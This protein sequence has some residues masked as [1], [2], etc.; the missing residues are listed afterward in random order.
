MDI[1]QFIPFIIFGALAA[2]VVVGL[3][4]I[5]VVMRQ[6][7]RIKAIEQFLSHQSAALGKIHAVLKA[8]RTSNAFAENAEIV[9][10]D[11]LQYATPIVRAAEIP[12][13]QSAEH[14]LWRA[15]GGMLDEYNRNPFVLEQ[16]RRLIKLDSEIA[17]AAD[18]FLNRAEQ[19]LRYL[20]SV[21]ADGLLAATFAD[22]MLG[23]AMTL[24]SQAKQLAQNN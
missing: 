23:Q 19:L 21:D 5:V 1:S 15:V 10:Q 20:A 13:R 7:K 2:A 12:P 17:R 11:L 14:A 24:L 16:L 22:G 8:K 6:T 18:G 9:Y 3:I 4:L